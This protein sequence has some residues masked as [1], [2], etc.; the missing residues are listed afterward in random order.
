[1]SEREDSLSH[2]RERPV[3]CSEEV[4]QILDTRYTVKPLWQ[5]IQEAQAS[6]V[7]AAYEAAARV[8]AQFIMMPGNEIPMAE[9]IR[10]L[11]SESAILGA[12]LREMEARLEEAKWWCG[13]HR[14]PHSHLGWEDCR[15]CKHFA[16]LESQLQRLTAE[17]AKVEG[18][19]PQPAKLDHP[20]R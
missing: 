7:K 18:V 12:Q 1:M 9:T 20:N 16:D 13:V 2:S 10:A 17:L 3:G 19:M 15:L 6:I 8:P 14:G 5:R 11:P 4:W